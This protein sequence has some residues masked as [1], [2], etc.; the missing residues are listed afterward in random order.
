[1]NLKICETVYLLFVCKCIHWDMA[2]N[3]NT[4][5]LKLIWSTVL[6]LLD[7]FLG[8]TFTENN[9]VN[10]NTVKHKVTKRVQDIWDQPP[11]RSDKMSDL[12]L[13][14]TLPDH[15]AFTVVSVDYFVAGSDPGKKVW[16]F[17]HRPCRQ[18]SPRS[19]GIFSTQRFLHFWTV[20]TLREQ[21]VNWEGCLL[22]WI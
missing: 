21:N 10:T 7:M 9:L 2:L 4:V 20:P 22:F 16:R 12:S 14:R 19:A 17:I 6:W 5:V 18:S 13:C 11:N 3:N 8:E 1:M 15:P